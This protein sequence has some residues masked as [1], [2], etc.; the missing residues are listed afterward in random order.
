[1]HPAI[2]AVT[3]QDIPLITTL[4]R[5]AFAEYQGK[6]D[7]PSS[8][9]SKSDHQVKAELNEGG[10]FVYQEAGAIVGCVFYRP[11]QDYV[12]LHRLAVLP[13]QRRRGIAQAL[14]EACEEYARSQALNEVRLSVRIV[15]ED[16]IAFYRRRGYQHF[17][18]G[19]HPGYVE[20][21]FVTLSKS[22]AET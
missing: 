22:L 16:T 10:A 18:Y 20:A 7:P 9:E 3:E 1:M 11:Y 21:T 4:I 8:A 13:E 12:Y 14:L 6:L 17:S 2:R 5:R 19:K 15:L